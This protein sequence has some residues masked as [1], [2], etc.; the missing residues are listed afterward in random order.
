M[1]NTSDELDPSDKEFSSRIWATLQQTKP[2]AQAGGVIFIFGA[3]TAIGAVGAM[4]GAV[5]AAASGHSASTS[6]RQSVER[7]CRGIQQGG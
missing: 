1:S 3:I 7:R 6:Y 4:V 2:V 5:V